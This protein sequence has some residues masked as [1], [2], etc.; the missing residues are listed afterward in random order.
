MCWHDLTLHL[1]F[2]VDALRKKI[3]LEYLIA[4]RGA[5]PKDQRPGRKIDDRDFASGRR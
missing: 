2:R 5:T 1:M 3:Y 4:P